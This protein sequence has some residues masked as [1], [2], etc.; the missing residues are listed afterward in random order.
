MVSIYTQ[1]LQKELAA[2]APPQ[3][4]QE[5]GRAPSALASLTRRGEGAPVTIFAPGA[6][7]PRYTTDY[8]MLLL[9]I[10]FTVIDNFKSDDLAQNE[11][12]R[13]KSPKSKPKK[14]LNYIIYS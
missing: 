12:L 14:I 11:I 10:P 8:N 9:N 7:N 6:R 13:R 4:P 1:M 2:E 5:R 3:T